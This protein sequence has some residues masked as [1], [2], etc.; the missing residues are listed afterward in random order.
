[1]QET[2]KCSDSLLDQKVVEQN[3]KILMLEANLQTLK[4]N[5]EQLSGIHSK[6]RNQKE[7][8]SVGIQTNDE[9]TFTI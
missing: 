6:C 8:V 5:F 7:K 4:K 9:V 2:H 1:M 3:S